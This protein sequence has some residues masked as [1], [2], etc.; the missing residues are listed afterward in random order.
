[1]Y[2]A[3]ATVRIPRAKAKNCAVMRFGQ[4]I[5]G[6]TGP[7]YQWHQTTK[8]VQ[9]IIEVSGTSK[10]KDF[11]VSCKGGVLRV[12]ECGKTLV[13]GELWKPVKGSELS[14]SLGTSEE[15]GPTTGKK[16]R[17]AD[18]R[19]RLFKSVFTSQAPFAVF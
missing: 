1:M 6:G 17:L 2:H 7:G 10:S 14:W 11:E 4:I 15:Q 18:C 12:V 3:V 9:V 16:V 19:T 5:N 13:D 8:E